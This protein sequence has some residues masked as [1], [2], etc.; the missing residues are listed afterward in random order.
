MSG[1]YIG[2]EFPKVLDKPEVE[3]RQANLTVEGQCR[4]SHIHFPRSSTAHLL[5]RLFSDCQA[6]L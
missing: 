6:M 1:R 5:L 3:Y 4:I 2:P